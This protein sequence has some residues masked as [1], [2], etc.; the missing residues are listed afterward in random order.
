[1]MAASD[2]PSWA[3]GDPLEVAARREAMRC[4]GCMFQVA[5][6]GQ[7]ACVRHAGRGGEQMYRCNDF[8]EAVECAHGSR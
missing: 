2:L 1:M 8:K 3:W 6:F 7:V 5:L 4:D